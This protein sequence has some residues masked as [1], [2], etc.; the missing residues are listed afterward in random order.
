MKKVFL[1]LAL[2]AFLA[3]CNSA[4]EKP[5]EGDVPTTP[6][7]DTMAPKIDTAVAPKVDTVAAPKVDTV[8]PAPKADTAKAATKKHK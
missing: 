5:A 7:A 6:P 1:V 2:G 4:A 8:K 3:S